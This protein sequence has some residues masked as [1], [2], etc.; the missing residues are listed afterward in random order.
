MTDEVQSQAS[1][2]RYTL[3]YG[4]GA[5]QW[6]TS[7][8]AEDYGAFF[9]PY[10]KPGM[11]ILDCGCGPGS[12]TLGFA[13]QVS[14]GEAIGVDREISQSAPITEAA[15]RDSV[16]NLRFEEGNIYR[17]SYPADSFDA[18][19]GSAVLG[20]VA[21][22]ERAVK[23]MLRVLKPGGIIGL[24]EF[25]HGGDIVYPQT[26]VIEQSIALY[27]RLRSENGHEPYAGRRLKE[28]LIANGCRVDYVRA[29][30]DQAS[31]PDALDACVERN[32]QLFVD[33]LGPQYEALGWCIPAEIGES[34]QAWRA[35]ARDPAA[36]YLA[37]WFEAV[38]IKHGNSP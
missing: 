15:A 17:L 20:S 29:F 13:R 5:M 22:A 9:L 11:R 33:I 28:Y 14:P 18:V 35:F 7:R 21:D 26:P 27:H 25:D 10:L 19:F 12:V 16:N 1:N 30:Y 34:I 23:E 6:M 38:G 24:K 37:C 8:T 2:E 36:I 31:D 3:G 32:N 4:E